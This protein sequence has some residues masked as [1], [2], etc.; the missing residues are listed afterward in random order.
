MQSSAAQRP[1]PNSTRIFFATVAVFLSLTSQMVAQPLSRTVNAGD[2]WA[3]NPPADTF[4]P[5]ALL[6]LRYLNEKESGQT[7]FVRFSKDRLSFVKGDGSPFR[8]WSTVVD[9]SN[10]TPEEMELHCRFL[11]KLGVNMVRV[12]T[13]IASTE[14]GS[15]ITDVNEKAIDAVFHF[16]NAAKE[17]GV[18]VTLC[19]YWA[20]LKAP[21]SW[22]LE[23][24]KPGD[25]PW[26]LLFFDPKLQEAYKTWMKALLTRVNPYTGKPINNDPT[27]AI[28]QFQRD[29][30]DL[31]FPENV[32][33][34]EKEL[35][36]KELYR[37]IRVKDTFD[38]G[39]V[40]TGAHV[41]GDDFEHGV[42]GFIDPWELTKPLTG[43]M[44]R[45][46]EYQVEFLG[47]WEM[48]F[49]RNTGAYLK[50]ELKCYQE[51]YCP[52]DWRKPNDKLNLLYDVE[53][54]AY[55]S[56]FNG[57]VGYNRYFSGVHIGPNSNWRI[58]PGDLISNRSVL[59]NPLE[60]PTDYKQMQA[61][62]VDYCRPNLIASCTWVNPN[63]YQSEGP[64]VVAAYQSLTGI[65]STYW[66]CSDTPNWMRDPRIA[67]TTTGM[68]PLNK[69]TA[70]VPE[71]M[72][73][74][75]ANSLLYRLGYLKQGEPVVNEGRSLDQ[76]WDRA[77]TVIEETQTPDP[78][79][80][81]TELQWKG[82]PTEISRLAF[83]VG[84]VVERPEDDPKIT[85]VMDISRFVDA[86]KKIVRGET[87]EIE[88][89]YGVGVCRIDSPKAK[90]VCGFLKDGGGTFRF[91]G[92][93]ISSQNDYASISVVAMD[94]TPL[95]T[96]KRILVQVGTTAR[97]TGW[98]TKPATFMNGTEN[99]RGEQI[100]STGAPPWLITNTKA[101]I[102]LKNPGLTHA[103]LLDPS[104]YSAGG[105]PIQHADGGSIV[106]QLPPQTMYLILH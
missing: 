97:L 85:S 62:R 63:L 66:F 42:S 54:W 2:S 68:N 89:N 57:I 92:L 13:Q 44:E 99:V 71:L 77:P 87:G 81:T 23:G 12:N 86:D 65:A 25:S 24:L 46:A 72:G 7:G 93:T 9:I 100:V 103:T 80:D 88:L 26:G 59:K 101:T 17:N 55:H 37:F 78:S 14:E 6:D 102:A 73:M 18:Y 79:K 16:I 8:F 58:D 41:D 33:A 94:D 56:N 106:V 45:R 21:A 35:V 95:D 70:S 53:R 91:D 29:D 28:I 52:S 84:P 27:V 105:V 36:G 32:S 3:F 5:S 40:R 31:M 104:G 15:K 98:E 51:I 47:Q 67:S 11:A 61:R 60:L 43:A 75:P 1:T 30:S 38:I 34:S 76:L 48:H 90:G 83:L 20:G 10:E 64:F 82:F 4:S 49:Y 39:I 69:W 74:F 50:Q 19:P 96:S 22:G